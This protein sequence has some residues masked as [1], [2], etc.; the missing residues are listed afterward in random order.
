MHENE[1]KNMNLFLHYMNHEEWY[2]SGSINIE[3]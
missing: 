2:E 3:E 1:N